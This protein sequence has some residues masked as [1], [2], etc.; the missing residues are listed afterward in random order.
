MNMPL[1]LNAVLYKDSSRTLAQVKE[2]ILDDAHKGLQ[3]FTMKDIE[4]GRQ[5]FR[6]R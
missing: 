5:T 3:E 2:M 1:A 4:V 6:K